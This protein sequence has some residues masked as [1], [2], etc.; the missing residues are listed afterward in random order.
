MGNEGFCKCSNYDLST[1]ISLNKNNKHKKTEWQIYQK[2]VIKNNQK[3]QNIQINSPN[4]NNVLK[5]G[6]KQN[7]LNKIQCNIASRKI[8]KFFREIK[9]KKLLLRYNNI[10]NPS[11][12]TSSKNDSVSS[13]KKGK[14]IKLLSNYINKHSI[15]FGSKS[16]LSGKNGFGIL[17]W[18]KAPNKPKD[19]LAKYIGS[20]ENNKCH[21]LGK[22]IINEMGI[23]AGE[24]N[25]DTGEGFG[26]YTHSNG[27]T[28]T[29]YWKKDLQDSYGIEE[30]NDN[31]SYEGE[32]LKGMKNGIGIYKWND[33]STY[34]GEWKNNVI[35]GYGVLYYGDQERIYIGEW[36]NNMKNGIGE[37]CSSKKKYFGKYKNDKKDGFGMMYWLTESKGFI[38]F[39][40]GGKRVGLGKYLAEDKSVFG[41]WNENEKIDYID[42]SNVK[43]LLAYAKLQ[44]Y[45]KFF[46]Y[47]LEELE[48]YMEKNDFSPSLI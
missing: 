32:Y 10:N 1:Q 37:F 2:K 28:Y 33:G 47:N 21:G 31:S 23:Y 20:F 26:I 11:S 19:F 7:I 48:E 5:R 4:Q 35:H 44:A 36:E 38:G 16:K 15:Y 29:G 8:T 46:T 39:W 34:K 41:F 17:K 6:V 22:L 43:V 12:I 45:I 13:F 30:W 27:S 9:I 40:K 3:L 25:N 18:V 24:F 14:N 42:V